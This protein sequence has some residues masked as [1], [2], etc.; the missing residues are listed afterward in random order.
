M[1]WK[2]IKEQAGRRETTEPAVADRRQQKNEMK[3]P[4]TISDSEN[5]VV[6][7]VTGSGLE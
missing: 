2:Q 7:K 1:T 6:T 4:F 3:S 5:T